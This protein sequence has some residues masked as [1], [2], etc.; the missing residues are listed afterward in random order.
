MRQKLINVGLI[1]VRNEAEDIRGWAK[2]MQY[3]C[4]KVVCVIDPESSDD[5][6]KI[7]QEEFPQVIIEYQDRS[8]GDSDEDHKGKERKL[9]CHANF[10]KYIKKYVKVG[11]WYMEM[12]P[13][14]RLDPK[15]FLLIEKDLKFAMENKFEALVFPNYYTYKDNLETIIDWY[16]HF[17]FGHLRQTKFKILKGNFTKGLKPHSASA[18]F[19]KEQYDTVAGFYHFCWMKDTRPVFRGWRDVVEY[20]TFKTKKFI[21]PI[22]DWKNIPELNNEGEFI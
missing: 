14:E 8:L 5:T 12:A 13:D 6:E 22:K 18:G 3:F 17:I 15:E 11:E 4:K 7:L 20:D 21:C 19:P 9:I 16:A 10:E 2:E 1:T